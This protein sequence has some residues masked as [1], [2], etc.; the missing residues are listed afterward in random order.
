MARGVL[1]F[2]IH[3]AALH[4][5]QAVTWQPTGSC[6]CSRCD[7]VRRCACNG[8]VYDSGFQSLLGQLGQLYLRGTLTTNCCSRL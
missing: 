7:C 3:A 2:K 4:V 1:A 6:N 8:K 5:H